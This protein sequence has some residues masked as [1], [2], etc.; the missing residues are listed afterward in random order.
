MMP[1]TMRGMG[2]G[3]AGFTLLEMVLATLISALVMGIFSVALTLSLR[4]WERQQYREHSLA[5]NLINLLKW[6]LAVFDPVQV[7]YDGRTRY[8]FFGD[9]H[10]LAFA[11]GQSVKAISR[12]APVVARYVFVPSSGIL[13]YAEMPYDP[14]H[15]ETL[16][17]FIQMTPGSE[18]SSPRFYPTPM[19]EFSLS[20]FS[21]ESTGSDSFWDGEGG[22]PAG[23]LVK[24]SGSTDDTTFGVLIVPNFLFAK[25]GENVEASK[26]SGTQR[27]IH[28]K[29][30]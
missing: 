26:L 18:G 16:Q 20:F 24:Y 22:I 25:K 5:P 4:V 8:I 6:Q 1:A 9:E 3:S 11:T 13:Y 30:K 28:R 21:E 29:R 23:V 2:R 27:Q 10:S 7:N 17:E 15:T 12:G 14:Y 19:R